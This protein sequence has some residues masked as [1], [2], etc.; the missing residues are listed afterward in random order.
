M[1]NDKIDKLPLTRLYEKKYGDHSTEESSWECRGTMDTGAY[2]ADCQ[3]Y[4][5]DRGDG[6]MECTC[7]EVCPGCTCYPETSMCQGEGCC[8]A[9]ENGCHAF[10]TCVVDDTKI[11]TRTYR[12]PWMGREGGSMRSITAK[13]EMQTQ[14]DTPP[15]A[16]PECPK[17]YQFSYDTGWC[18]EVILGCTDYTALNYDQN[19]TE[20]DGTCIHQDCVEPICPPGT[21]YDHS[22]QQCVEIGSTGPD[23]PQISYPT[24]PDRPPGGIADLPITP[25]LVPSVW[26]GNKLW[27]TEN[28]RATHYNNGDP[29]PTGYTNDQWKNL[30]TGAYTVYNDDESYAD[31]HGYLYNW[32][33]VNDPRGI[34]PNGWHVPSDGDW[35]DLE[36]FITN[37]GYAGIEGDA[38]KEIGNEHWVYYNDNINGL[39]IYGFT[40]LPG[41]V[42][43][44]DNGH[45][46]YIR[47][48]SYFWSSTE[49][50]NYGAYFMRLGYNTS[51]IYRYKL[52]IRN[53]FSVRC[54]TY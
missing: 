36:D 21:V 18:C 45:Y 12:R 52:K 32:Y 46:Y 44:A 30:T 25:E 27:M 54:V 19:A 33:V 2:G 1:S 20:D 15:A 26:I 29:I 10:G 3:M 8:Y 9:Q 38:L 48:Y 16:P 50:S 14:S 51:D 43:F 23:H 31:T 47:G 35:N 37:D 42:R 6:W 11:K 17:G 7:M 41:G 4:Q 34:C 49:G 22:F 53:G 13:A 24:K 28:L 40:A 39:D 5:W